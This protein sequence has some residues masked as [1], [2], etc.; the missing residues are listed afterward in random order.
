MDDLLKSFVVG[1]QD[2]KL[3]VSRLCLARDLYDPEAL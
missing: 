2:C 1:S 3:V